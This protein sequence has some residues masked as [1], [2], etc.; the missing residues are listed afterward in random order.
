MQGALFR[1]M[2]LLA[3]LARNEGAGMDGLALCEEV[4]VLAASSL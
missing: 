4:G 1:V 2:L 3:D